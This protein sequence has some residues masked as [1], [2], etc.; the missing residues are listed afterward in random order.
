MQV[1]DWTPIWVHPFV[2]QGQY[3]VLVHLFVK[4]SRSVDN[5][6]AF[7]VFESNYATCY[8]GRR[9]KIFQRGQQKKGR[10]LAKIPIN[11]TIWRLPG[12]AQRK[13]RPK[14]SKKRPKNSKKGWKKALLS[15]YVP[16]L[17]IQGG[18]PWP[19]WIFKL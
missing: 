19:P 18:G 4:L 17:K 8:Q 15:L 9:Q 13:K 2:C 5:E 16:S 10:K 3:L 12:E 14:N 1:S 11:C 6:V 7:S